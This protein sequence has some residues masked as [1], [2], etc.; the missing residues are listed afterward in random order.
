MEAN[1]IQRNIANTLRTLAASGALLKGSVSRVLLGKKKR[2]R[3][4]RIAYLLT[5]KGDAQVTRSVYVPKSQ[6][7]TVTT[8]IR[9]Y[10]NARKAL[11]KLVELNVQLFK[12]TRP[13]NRIDSP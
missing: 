10:R 13:P 1:T 7:A 5:Y 9:N 2:G 11:E 8:M 6:V 3:G 12:T 4:D